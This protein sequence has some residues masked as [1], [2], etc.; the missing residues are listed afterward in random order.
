M[1]VFAVISILA[2]TIPS[3]L[4]LADDGHQQ[5]PGQGQGQQGPGQGPG[6]GQGQQGPG[7]GQGQQGPG[8]GQGQQGPGQGQGQQ[9]PGQ[10][11]GC[12]DRCELP[13]QM[14]CFNLVCYYNNAENPDG[15]KN[16]KV[17]S[18]FNKLVT[19]D[20]G[21]VQDDSTIPDNP[22]FEVSCEDKLIYNNSARRFT[23]L[24]GTRIQGEAGPHPSITIPRGALH[25]GVH[26]TS[27][28]HIAPSVFEIDTG[29]HG[30]L[31]TRGTCYIWTGVPLF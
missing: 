29:S 14:A 4:I 15:Y 1:R 27:G 23:D 17:A 12:P 11:P 22:E 28:D 8:Q 25:S 9:G 5:G 6:Q 21:E 24:L 31:R 7:Q 10:Q 3:Q 16:C 2:L 13:T 18:R 26:G 20:G 19:I 30:L